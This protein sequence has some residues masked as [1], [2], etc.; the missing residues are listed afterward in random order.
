MAYSTDLFHLIQAMSKSEKRYFKLFSSFQAGNKVYISLF[1][2]ISKQETYDE[3]KLKKQ[4]KISAFPTVKTYLYNLILRSLRSQQQN[5]NISLQLKDMLKDVEI[6]YQ[7]GLYQQCSRL[8]T[9]ARKIAKQY[10][11]HIHLLELCQYEHL[12][13]SL[14]LDPHHRK[15]LIENGYKEV[16]EALAAY[17]QLSD[18][19]NKILIMTDYM[20]SEGRRV[21]NNT[22]KK[23]LIQS[24]EPIINKDSETF[25]SYKAGILFYNIKELFESNELNYQKAYEMSKRYI[26]HMESDPFLLNQ[27][28]NNY[29]VGLNNLMNMQQSLG[30]FKELKT[31]LEKMKSIP[32]PSETEK[33]RVIEYTLPKEIVYYVSLGKYEEGLERIPIIEKQLSIYKDKMGTPFLLSL[34]ANVVELYIVS[35]NIRKALQWNNRILNSDEIE[36]YIDY[37]TN[38]RLCEIIIHF[39]LGNMEKVDSL[40]KSFQLLLMKNKGEYQYENCILKFLK[41]LL[42]LEDEKELL[43]SFKLLREELLELLKDPFEKAAFSFFD[44]IPWL[45][46]KIK[47]YAGKKG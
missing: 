42:Y 36:T 38:S 33:I 46:K 35:D 27:E 22:D 18:Y 31:N 32:L 9:R 6:L 28:I 30:L 10:E 17:T 25:L 4:L 41:N 19:R 37:Y 14:S 21:K 26:A 39:E 1:N 34:Y 47:K 29:L 23:R 43:K 45:D 3:E 16:T 20:H 24:L 15:K 11:K 44:L 5:Q 8:L 7:K 13:T 2:A 40:I 12:L